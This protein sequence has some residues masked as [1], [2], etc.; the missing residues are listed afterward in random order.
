MKTTLRFAVAAFA[1]FALTAQAQAASITWSAPVQATT[2]ADLVGGPEI[3]FVG[4]PF[5][6]GGGNAA[7]TFF[8]GDGGNTG[9]T[10]LNMV[11]DSHGWNGAG[12]TVTIDGL[13]SGADY[14]VQLLGAGDTRGC[15][16][17]RTQAADDGNG[18]VS[19]DFMRGASSVVG[20]F[21][22]DAATQDIMIVAGTV[23]GVDPGLSGMIVATSAG[24][25]VSAF[26]Y[27]GEA[28]SIPEPSSI[29][30]SLFGGLAL[31]SLRR[32]R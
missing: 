21:T 25:V 1:A 28:V 11:Y 13:T 18:N 9:S 23:D 30:M 20:A 32:R 26:N 27:A 10:G 14:L 31:L 15:C 3:D 2:V 17:T 19:G 5:P 22:A 24:E 12:A 7:G 6:G 4:A 8:T 16:A 29:L